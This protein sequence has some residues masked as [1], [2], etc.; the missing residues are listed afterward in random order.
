MWSW[1]NYLPCLPLFIW[2]FGI[3]MMII[4]YQLPHPW[5]L[6]MMP[7]SAK[8]FQ[9]ELAFYMKLLLTSTLWKRHFSAQFKDVFFTGRIKCLIHGKF[10]AIIDV[11]YYYL[12]LFPW[13][14][15]GNDILYTKLYR[16]TCF[17]FRCHHS[18]SFDLV[19]ILKH[20]KSQISHL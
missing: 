5:Y 13:G 19:N 9:V 1:A 20:S 3:V 7:D 10:Y 2:E 11:L 14:I 16:Q 4:I 15:M 17:K 6:L 12:Q 18:L 8:S